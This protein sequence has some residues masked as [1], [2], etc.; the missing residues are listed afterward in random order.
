MN[1]PHVFL[2][3]SVPDSVLSYIAD[4][5]DYTIWDKDEKPTTEQLKE[6]LRHSDGALLTSLSADEELVKNCERLKVISTATVG[7]DRF[8][9]IGL[10]KHNVYLTNTPYVLDETV[11]DLLFGLIL[12]GSRRIAELHKE[13]IDGNWTA[14]TSQSSLYGQDVYK[15]TLGIIGMGR[16]GEKVVH[17][18]KEGFNMSVLYHN[19]SVRP[20]AEERYGAKKVELDT[21]LEESDIVV[22]M[23]PLTEETT[24]L[25]G[26]EELSKMKQTA[27]LVN[28]ARGP[29]IDEKALIEALT[30]N[31]IFGAALDVFEQEPLPSNHP[32]LSLKNVT[33]TPHIGSATA[34]TREAMAMRAA[35]NLVAGALGKTPVDI[36]KN[37]GCLGKPLFFNLYPVLIWNDLID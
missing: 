15:K 22:L 7:Y 31:E 28:G 13:V 30:T 24:H 29:V 21:L 2:A 33:L 12:S 23:V 37:K 1:K 36:V 19:R 34:A 26:K 14:K 3:Q 25:I 8:D 9:P 17:R 4:H 20:E 27:L 35:E 32:F 18:A 5:C 6:I 16:I 11:A 10:A